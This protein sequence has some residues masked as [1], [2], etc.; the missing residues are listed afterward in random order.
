MQWAVKESLNDYRKK[1]KIW[2]KWF[3]WYPVKATVGRHRWVWCE[4]VYRKGSFSYEGETC[5]VYALTDF[6]LLLE[7]EK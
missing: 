5:Y 7:K 4:Q 2:H 1:L 3:A 6:D